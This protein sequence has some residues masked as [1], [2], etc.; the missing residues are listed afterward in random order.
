MN[1]LYKQI[2]KYSDVTILWETNAERLL[3]SE[4][5]EVNGVQIRQSDGRMSKVHGPKVM[6]ACGGFEGSRELYGASRKTMPVHIAD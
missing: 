1:A 5:G 4:D 2:Q 3:Q 6:L